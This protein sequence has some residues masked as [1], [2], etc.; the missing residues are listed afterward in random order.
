LKYV[1]LSLRDRCRDKHLL[2]SELHRRSSMSNSS[3]GATGAGG[4]PLG[5]RRSEPTSYFLGTDEDDGL[6]QS[7]RPLLRS[8][9][10]IMDVK[11]LG[12]EDDDVFDTSRQSN[13]ASK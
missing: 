5:R 12:G 10:G 8:L 11:T 1:F 3:Y 13:E 2:L 4:T 6:L 7:E 9:S